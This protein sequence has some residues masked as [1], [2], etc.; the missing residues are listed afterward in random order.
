MDISS[1]PETQSHG[2]PQISVYQDNTP[3][4][5]EY[6]ATPNAGRVENVTSFAPIVNGTLE[7]KIGVYYMHENAFEYSAESLPLGIE[8]NAGDLYIYKNADDTKK[9]VVTLS[10]EGRIQISDPSITLQYAR[11]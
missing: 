1:N 7:N 9:P 2:Y 6:L 3:I 11:E 4:Y 5:F 10:K 8:R